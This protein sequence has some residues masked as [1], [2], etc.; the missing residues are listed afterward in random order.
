MAT[1]PETDVER[2]L[3]AAF[4]AFMEQVAL[5]NEAGVDVGAVLSA[6]MRAM[7]GEDDYNDLPPLVRMMLG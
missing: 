1:M 2:N 4:A 5:A 6:N 3:V 7:M